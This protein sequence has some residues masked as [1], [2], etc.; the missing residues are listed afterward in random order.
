MVEMVLHF[1]GIMRTVVVCVLLGM[2]I[3]H[4]MYGRWQQILLWP[5]FFVGSVGVPI[6][7]LLIPV[8]IAV[9]YLLLS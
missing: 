3:G 1:K 4:L 7:L 6:G 5:M 8:G 9:V 2:G